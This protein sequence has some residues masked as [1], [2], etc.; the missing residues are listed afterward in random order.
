MGNKH[1]PG[2]WNWHAQGDANDYCL[3]TSG[4]RW[5]ISFR[6]N[7]EK[8]YGEQLAN[9]Q[10]IAA[11][12]DLLAALENVTAELSQLHSHHHPACEGG[13]PTVEYIMR[14]RQAIAQA[15]GG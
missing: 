15:N 10:L 5:I 14:A 11:A 12:P 13:C 2:P 1:T 9:A 7:G 6:Q 4:A 3:L 8:L